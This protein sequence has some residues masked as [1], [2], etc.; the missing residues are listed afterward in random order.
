MRLVPL[1]PRL[2]N[3]ADRTHT[4]P[5]APKRRVHSCCA[6]GAAPS[7]PDSSAGRAQSLTFHLQM[8]SSRPSRSSWSLLALA[9]AAV[10]ALASASGPHGDLFIILDGQKTLG[11]PLPLQLIDDGELTASANL[12]SSVAVPAS[13]GKAY[14]EW[15]SPLTVSAHVVIV[16]HMCQDATYVPH[17]SK[18][19]PNRPSTPSLPSSPVWLAAHPYAP[20][21]PSPRRHAGPRAQPGSCTTTSPCHP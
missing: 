18:R 5:S 20:P 10:S 13:V 21:A 17:V 19:R 16:V 9:L 11:I 1:R 2:S 12:A 6:H 4:R 15:K 8:R 3:G 7:L 14:L